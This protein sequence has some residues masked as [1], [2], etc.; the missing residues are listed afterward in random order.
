MNYGK[1]N[2]TDIANGPGVRVSLFVSGCRNHCQGCFNSCAW[3]FN[4]GYH[5][6]EEIE[7]I[8]LNQLNKNYISGLSILGGEPTEPE[9]WSTVCEL[10]AKVKRLYPEKTVWVY[11]GRVF[12]EIK[13]LL[14]ENNA[15]MDVLVDGPFIQ[16][17]KDI[18]LQFR[19]SSN[20]RLININETRANGRIVLW[21]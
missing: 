8:I 21:K 3:D 10:I 7:K 20:Q 19:G 5:Y 6:T 2:L 12:E 16:E 13:N 17:K 18:S 11:T 9:N 1:I 15:A 4:Y 14:K